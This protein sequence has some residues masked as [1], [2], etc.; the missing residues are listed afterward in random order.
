M[1]WLNYQHFFYFWNAARCG[2]V[3]EAASRLRLAQPTVS[4]QIKAFEEIIGEPLFKREGRNL[5]LSQTGKIAFRYAEQIFS[6]GQEFLDIIDGKIERGIRHLKVGVADVVP[7]SIAFRLIDAVLDPEANCNVVCTEDKTERLLADLAIDGLDLVIADRPIPNTVKIK[8]FNH[9]IGES[10][11]T[12]LATARIAKRLRRG[13]PGSLNE[14]ALLLPG[15][16]SA[17]RLQMDTWFEKKGV[18]VNALG[19]F[20]DR[21]LMK[22]AARAGRGVIPVPAAVEKEV[23]SEFSLQLVGRADDLFERFYLI[24]L[25]RRLQNPLVAKILKA[26]Q[27]GLGK[28]IGG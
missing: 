23:M 5:T 16:E 14:A 2:S 8:A 27:K 13:F 3:T 11:V 15:N 24:S 10:P 4:A 7:K 9:F 17:L 19:S 6:L 1:R 12:F 22:I 18:T 25:E 21:A 20:E 28:G 26:G